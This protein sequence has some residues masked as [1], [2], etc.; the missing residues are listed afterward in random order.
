[1]D[2]LITESVSQK[3]F[4][5]VFLNTGRLCASYIS[6]V[7]IFSTLKVMKI[8]SKRLF[9]KKEKIKIRKN[10]ETRRRNAKNE[11]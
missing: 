3:R 11:I 5:V 9:E 10:E 6:S 7:E 1:M 2:P 8:Q 4:V